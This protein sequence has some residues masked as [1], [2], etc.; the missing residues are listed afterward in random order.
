MEEGSIE[1]PST[2]SIE[3]SSEQTEDISSHKDF[4]NHLLNWIKRTIFSASLFPVPFR[5]PFYAANTNYLDRMK[6]EGNYTEGKECCVH[7]LCILIVAR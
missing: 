5:F 2:I 3:Y 6:I 4:P 1:W 7:S